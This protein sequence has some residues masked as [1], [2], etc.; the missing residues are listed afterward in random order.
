MELDGELQVLLLL[1]NLLD[2]REMLVVSLN[3]FT[4]NCVAANKENRRK[5]AGG[6]NV[7]DQ[8]IVTKNTVE[9]KVEDFQRL[10]EF[11]VSITHNSKMVGPMTEKSVWIFIT[12]FLVFVS[13]TQ[14]SDF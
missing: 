14:F 7:Q 10:F 2:S 6:V 3:N 8:A 11:A 9:V 13:I 4:P 12:L 1:S 5:D